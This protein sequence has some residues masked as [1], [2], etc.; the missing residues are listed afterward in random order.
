MMGYIIASSVI[1]LSQNSQQ[2]FGLLCWRWPFLIEV[3]LLTPLYCGLYFI[4][5][6]DISIC[7]KRGTASNRSNNVVSSPLEK[8]PSAQNKG[9]TSIA[10]TVD[11]FDT[12]K[13]NLTIDTSKNNLTIDTLLY[14]DSA[15][16]PVKLPMSPHDLDSI[17]WLPCEEEEEES[18]DMARRSQYLLK[19][20][21]EREE[22]RR[23]RS[24]FRQQAMS[25][26]M[27][28]SMSLQHAFKGSSDKMMT[29]L[30]EYVQYLIS[31]VYGLTDD[32]QSHPLFF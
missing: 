25:A 17:N 13:N 31:Y 29:L 18:P 21:K 22:E 6:E 14:R 2:C 12:S 8:A 30:G 20:V 5:K 24:S 32:D 7:L 1:S 26:S 4:P 27:F 3:L 9:P 19:K 11:N 23:R 15:I 10:D 16:K 28:D